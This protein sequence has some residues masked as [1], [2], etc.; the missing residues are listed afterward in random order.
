MKDFVSKY[1]SF[2]MFPPCSSSLVAIDFFQFI[3]KLSRHKAGSL[4]NIFKYHFDLK[5]TLKGPKLDLKPDFA[6]LDPGNNGS[7]LDYS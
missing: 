1:S 3:L 2:H 7:K 4:Q 6:T 5:T